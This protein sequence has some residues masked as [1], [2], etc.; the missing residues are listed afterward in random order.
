MHLNVRV[1]L[2]T[3]F[4]CLSMKVAASNRDA[5]SIVHVAWLSDAMRRLKQT[6]F[7]AVMVDL[8]LPDAKGL[9]TLHA[10]TRAAPHLP[11]LVL[12][13]DTLLQQMNIVE[14][15][16]DDYLLKNRLD[17]D[18]LMGAL[19]GSIARKAREGVMFSE[20]QRAQ[21][22]RNSAV[23][24]ILS[25][26]K[27]GLITF[28]NPVAERLIGW[29]YAEAAGR[30]LL[31]VFQLIEATTRERVVPRMESKPREGR[32]IMLLPPCLLVRRDGHESPIENQAALIYDRSNRI[33]GMV[34]VFHDLP[35]SRTMAHLLV[36]PAERDAL[37]HLPIRALRTTPALVRHFPLPSQQNRS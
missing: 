7:Q 14:H 24:G 12:G 9:E 31:E 27:A 37:K 33:S 1:L 35:E 29:P 13:D 20:K 18:T 30:H 25:A 34:V 28:L 19:H 21:L 6:D 11:I 2:I 10:L 17:A 32:T 8:D 16:A 4:R 15:G 26:D 23:D 5:L 22:T 36:R 3:R